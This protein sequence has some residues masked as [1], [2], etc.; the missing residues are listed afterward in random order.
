MS[1]TLEIAADAS[2]SLPTESF[3]LDRSRYAGK[4]PGICLVML[5]NNFSPFPTGPDGLGLS[6][7]SNIY[8]IDKPC[9]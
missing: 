4:K 6:A 5:Y 9:K 1:N 8:F 7:P 2:A 3:P